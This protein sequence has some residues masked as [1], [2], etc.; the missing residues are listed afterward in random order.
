M[1]IDIVTPGKVFTSELFM[2]LSA[3]VALAIIDP[4]QSNLPVVCPVELMG[5]DLCPGKGLGRSLS[6]LLRGDLLRAWEAHWLGVPALLILVVRI[7]KL[8]YPYIFN[9]TLQKGHTHA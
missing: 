8:S 6:F 5:F 4:T 3:L 9:H 7:V 2:W 1:K